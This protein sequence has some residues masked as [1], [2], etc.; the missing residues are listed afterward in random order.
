[1]NKPYKFPRKNLA[2]MRF[3][4]LTVL[5]YA[6]RSRYGDAIWNVKCDCGTKFIARANSLLGA[7]TRSCGCLRAEKSRERLQTISSNIS[8][9]T[10]DGVTFASYTSAAASL[11]CSN[12]TVSRHA[13]SGKPYHGHQIVNAL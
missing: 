10:V 7:Q 2:G 3:G 9:V 13:K 8:P 6:G 12:R 4:R 5:S 11:G 1:M